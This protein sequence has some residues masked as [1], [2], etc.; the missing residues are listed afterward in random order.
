M[1]PASL[2]SGARRAALLRRARRRRQSRG[3]VLFIVAVTLGL[4][5]VMGVYGLSA[6]SADIRA[7]GHMR[8]ALQGQRAGEA[9]L[10]MTAETFN[11]T[12]A[13]NLVQQMN[14]GQGQATDCVTAA[15][16]TGN[17]LTRAAEACI[18]L[19]PT[20][21]QTIA[22]ATTP[23]KPWNV[24][25]SPAQPGFSAQSFGAVA[26]QPY[27]SVEVTNPINT[28]VMTGNSQTVRY[29]QLTATVFVRLKKTS[30]SAPETQVVGRGRITV[31]PSLANASAPSNF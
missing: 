12:I 1:M 9:G 13:Q 5:A 7:S 18:R 30:T 26:N 15:P 10:M 14:L 28:E 6:T 2:P 24:D 4:L 25:P 21:M 23:T 27:V 16:Y 17:V 11:P 22:L 31:G 8:E 29:S 3:A 20:K 19:D